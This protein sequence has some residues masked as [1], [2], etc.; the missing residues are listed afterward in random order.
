[1]ERKME[2]LEAKVEMRAPAPAHGYEPDYDEEEES[3]EEDT[4]GSAP[5]GRGQAE[6][7]A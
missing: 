7:T 5:A 4:T 3:Y 2:Y 6:S 1:M